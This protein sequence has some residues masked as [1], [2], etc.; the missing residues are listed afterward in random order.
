[1]AGAFHAG[2]IIALADET[3]TAAAMWETNPSSALRPESFPVTGQMSASVIRNAEGDPPV[4]HTHAASASAS[5][6]LVGE[7]PGR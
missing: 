4:A 5:P 3:A 1:V 7:R 6:A 2:A